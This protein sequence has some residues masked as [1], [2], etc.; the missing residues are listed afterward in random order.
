MQ[1]CNDSEQPNLYNNICE[2]GTIIDTMRNPSHQKLLTC[3]YWAL[4]P[5]CPDIG[6]DK[7]QTCPFAHWDTGKLA[8][9]Q[10]QR[11]TCFDWYY[12]GRCSFGAGCIDEHR[13]TGVMGLNQGS[14]FVKSA[15]ES[16]E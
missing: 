5:R 4:G 10:D 2:L 16:K 3:R 15:K 9:F 13:E 7:I 8:R 12:N 1:F 14:K 6:P 11:G